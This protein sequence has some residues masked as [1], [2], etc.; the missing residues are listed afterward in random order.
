MFRNPILLIPILGLLIAG[1]VTGALAASD[2]DGRTISLTGTGIAK[3]RPDTAHV[4]TGVI[5]EGPTAHEALEKNTAAMAQVVAELKAQGLAPKD[6][7]TTNFSVHPR[8]QHFKN[9][10]PAAIVGYR[11][12]NSVRIAV[13]DLMKLGAI[14]DKVVSLGS[15]K[16]GGVEFSVDDPVPL[17]NQARKLAME[18]AISKANLYA[19]AAGARLGKVLKISEG[20][21]Q[22]PPQPVFARATA[23]AKAATP[24][25]P[26]EQSLQVHVNVTWE[27]E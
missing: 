11:V 12:V 18:N 15:N 14:L 2:N 19:E 8:Y 10:K 22:R 17:K 20:V 26:G 9:G 24:I 27:L 16:I 13:H 5:S 23:N 6:I 1:P 3:A 21:T 4:S 7:Q 25:E